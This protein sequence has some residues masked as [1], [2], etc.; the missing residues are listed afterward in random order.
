MFTGLKSFDLYYD[1]VT[2]CVGG[3][4]RKIYTTICKLSIHFYVNSYFIHYVLMPVRFN[5][6]LHLIV[7]GVTLFICLLQ[8][9]SVH[10]RPYKNLVFEGGGIRGIAYAGALKVFEEKQLMKDVE[11]VAGTSVG[12]IV[13]CL[14]SVG[15]TADEM[16]VILN[17]LK[18]Q[19][20]NDGQGFFIGG[21]QRM[22]RRFG[23]YRGD[24]L[25]KWLGRLIAAKTGSADMT[26]TQLHRLAEEPGYR[27]LFVL[28]TNLSMQRTEVFSY[29]TYP[30]MKIKTA[31]RASI[32]IPIYFGA[33]FL[34]STGR[35]YNKQKDCPACDIFL[36]GGITANYPITTFDSGS[37]NSNTLGFKLERPEQAERYK[38]AGGLARYDIHNFGSYIGA[39]YNIFIEQLNSTTSFEAEKKRTIYISTGGIAPR[40][41][42]MSKEEKEILFENGRKTAEEFLK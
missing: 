34:D 32:S 29:T 33:V 4:G 8:C 38:T 20:F 27:D 11:N 28:S 12:A 14:L 23:W 22:R 24:A 15:Y 25:E 5:N 10:A 30:N 9:S 35:K 37:I 17:D 13:A 31:V 7:C 19:Q 42:K 16:A 39:L 6:T 41:R 3:N 36:D 40:I 1:K 2:K 26:F 18:L 21:E